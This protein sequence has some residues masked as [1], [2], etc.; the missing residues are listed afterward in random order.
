MSSNTTKKLY[1]R[2]MAAINL[3]EDSQS[4]RKLLEGALGKTELRQ[5]EKDFITKTINRKV[6]N[7]SNAFANKELSNFKSIKIPNKDSDTYSI[8]FKIECEGVPYN[9]TGNR[10]Y[11]EILH[12]MKNDKNAN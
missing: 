4:L 9:V 5:E 1:N 10:D 6:N 7:F 11:R 12:N 8:F 3:L 2:Y